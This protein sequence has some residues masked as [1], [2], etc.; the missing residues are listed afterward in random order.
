MSKTYKQY[1][2]AELEFV[3]D[4]IPKHMMPAAIAH[5]L[6]RKGQSVTHAL[7]QRGTTFTKLRK[8]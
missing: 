3:V 2:Q 8:A 1:S 5:A 4:C 7:M 6:G